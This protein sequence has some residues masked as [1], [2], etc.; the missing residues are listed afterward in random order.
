MSGSGYNYLAGAG[1]GCHTGQWLL[2][3]CACWWG[4]LLLA[5]AFRPLHTFT[6]FGSCLFVEP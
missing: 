2:F 3:L 4:H 6:S 1:V 5:R